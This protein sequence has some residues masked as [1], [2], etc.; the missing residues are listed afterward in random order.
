MMA[1]P[2]AKLVFWHLAQLESRHETKKS[3]LK[4]K[5]EKTCDCAARA[6][7]PAARRTCDSSASSQSSW[8]MTGWRRDMC[9]APLMGSLL[10]E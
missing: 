4:R 9:S 5:K 7:Q 8:S 2:C 10:T 6:Q 1:G 3:E